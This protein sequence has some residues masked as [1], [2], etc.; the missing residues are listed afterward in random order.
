M[1][2]NFITTF[3]NGSP[4]L[5]PMDSEEGLQL[6]YLDNGVRVGGF[7]CISYAPAI[8]VVVQVHSSEDTINAMKAD[9]SFVWLEDIPEVENDII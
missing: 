1:R 2:A 5:P 8:S 7:V 6:T 4:V 9:D 3:A